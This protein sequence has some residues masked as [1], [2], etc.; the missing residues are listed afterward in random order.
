MDKYTAQDMAARAHTREELAKAE[1]DMAVDAAAN[2]SLNADIADAQATD[3]RIRANQAAQYA[4]E[5]DTDR[6]VMGH[7][8][9]HERAAASNNAFGFYL[10][11]GILVAGLMVTGIYLYWRNNNPD[12][13]NVYAAPPTQTAPSTTVVTPP[14][15]PVIPPP[16]VVVNPPASAPT[17]PAQ[18]AQPS[19]PTSS[20]STSRPNVI[21]VN[22]PAIHNDVHVTTPSTGTGDTSGTNGTTGNGGTTTDNSFNGSS[23]PPVGGTDTG[24]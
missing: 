19:G 20:S 8:L 3:A 21:N 4:A 15:A 12:S 11:L 14:P 18:P 23:T 10:T 2:E 17:P 5:A 22:P 9:A 1:R 6:H 24:R 7:Q 16:A 13:I